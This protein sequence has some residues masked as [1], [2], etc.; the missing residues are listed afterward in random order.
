MD[1]MKIRIHFYSDLNLHTYFF[2]QPRYDSE[3]GLKFLKKLKQ[4]NDVKCEILAD[5]ITLFE[6][7]DDVM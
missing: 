7:H 5:L 4:P 6:K 1:M 3:I 2:E